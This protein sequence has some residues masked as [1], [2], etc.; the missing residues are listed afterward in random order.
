MATTGPPGYIGLR[1]GKT[2][3]CRS[4]LYRPV[5]DY[6]FGYRIIVLKHTCPLQLHMGYVVYLRL[7][8]PLKPLTVF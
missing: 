4:Q 2:T 6:E 8:L 1:A 5:G 7:T 3:L